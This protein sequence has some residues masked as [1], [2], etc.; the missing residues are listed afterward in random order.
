MAEKAETGKNIQRIINGVQTLPTLPAIAARVS[1][2]A[3]SPS[4]SAADIAAVVLHDQVLAAKILSIVNSSAYGLKRK[5]AS[6]QEAV[7]FLGTKSLSHLAVSLSIINTFKGLESKRFPR[8]AFWNHSVAVALFARE[9][10]RTSSLSVKPDEVFTAGLLHDLGKIATDQFLHDDF[11]KILDLIEKQPMPFYAAE[12]RVL[13]LNHTRIGEWVARN[14]QLPISTIVTIRHHHEKPDE[15]QGFNQSL[16]PIVDF[17]SVA[18][19]IAITS[20]IG[21]SGSPVTDEPD[22]A[23]FA[24]ISHDRQSAIA[25]SEELHD[26]VLSSLQSLGL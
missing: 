17:I 21:S 9:M 23:I 18:N 3:N 12:D 1:K 19:W 24:R 26:D 6:I 2:L 8:T 14:W 7:T 20:G 10:A 25:L 22:P 16:D 11:E 15:R 5:I 4:S 13:G